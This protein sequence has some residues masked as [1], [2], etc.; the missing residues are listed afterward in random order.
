MYLDLRNTGFIEARVQKWD[1]YFKA[2]KQLLLH[3][4]KLLLF[5]F[6]HI[7]FLSRNLGKYAHISPVKKGTIYVLSTVNTNHT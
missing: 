6:Q 3:T 7:A 5:D 4:D 2:Q 1:G